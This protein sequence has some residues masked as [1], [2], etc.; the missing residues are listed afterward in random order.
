MKVFERTKSIVSRRIA[1]ELF[2]VPIAGDLANMERIF[3]LTAVAEFIWERLDGHTSLSDICNDIVTQFE[4][5]KEQADADVR[6]F[7]AEL[8]T[9]GLI[10]EAGE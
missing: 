2:L 5:R 4:T 7:V 10:R 1:G 6:E 9:E 8:L 3:A